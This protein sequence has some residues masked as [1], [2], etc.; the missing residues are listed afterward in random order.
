METVWNTAETECG[1]QGDCDCPPA[2]SDVTCNQDE[3]RC[4]LVP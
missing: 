1:E 2:P 4:E 3:G